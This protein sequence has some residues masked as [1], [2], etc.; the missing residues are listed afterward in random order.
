MFVVKF[1]VGF[2]FLFSH[3]DVAMLSLQQSHLCN[4]DM[5]DIFYS[6]RLKYFYK[7]RK[8]YRII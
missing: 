3:A 8:S 5:V 2:R 7:V 4:C 6:R 1:P